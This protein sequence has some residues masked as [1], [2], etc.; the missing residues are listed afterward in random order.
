MVTGG[1]RAAAY[2]STL[3]APMM[4]A[5]GRGLIVNI[6][7]VLDRPYGVACVAVSP[8][9]VGDPGVLTT[10]GGVH[11]TPALARECGFARRRVAGHRPWPRGADPRRGRGPSVRHLRAAH[12]HVTPRRD[13]S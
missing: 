10:S 13:A 7:W 1:L 6:T 4:V 3:A 2:A 9:F 11:T 12:C 5:A 8:G